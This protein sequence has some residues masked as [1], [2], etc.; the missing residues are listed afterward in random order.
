MEGVAFI[1]TDNGI[2]VPILWRKLFSKSVQSK[3]VCSTKRR[4]TINNS[5]LEL[6]GN[7]AHHDVVAQ[8]ANILERTIDT[9]LDNIPNV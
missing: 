4:G 9:L 3:L 5:D 2:A 6:C 8:F 1:L 7:I